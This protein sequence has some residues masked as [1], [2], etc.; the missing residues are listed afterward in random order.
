MD[1]S[2]A[3]RQ[4]K[5]ILNALK[6]FAREI[7][8]RSWR[9]M[10]FTL[11]PL[12]LFLTGAALAPW[13]PIRAVC[14]IGAGL[15]MIRGFI[16]Y[17]DF[18]HGAILRGSRT[19]GIFM[20]ALAVLML[21]PP[22]SWRET[23]NYHHAHVG[24]IGAEGD[25]SAEAI[26]TDI[27]SFPLLSTGMWSKLSRAQ[28]FRY[29]FIRHPLTIAFA[30]LTVFMMSI[31]LGSL[32]RNPRKHWPSALFFLGHLT[33]LAALGWA[34]G[35]PMVVFVGV[36]PMGIAAAL[37]AYLF[38]AQH[39]FPGVH[40]FTP[41][42]WNFVRASLETASYLKTGR[43]M[44]WITGCIGYHHV[45]HLN[46][47]IPF[48]RLPEAMAAVPELQYPTTTRLRP[49]DIAGCFRANLWDEHSHRMVSYRDA[50][51]MAASG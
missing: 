6:P 48:Y 26:A 3:D 1:S 5:E 15:M 41:A 14:S 33:Y 11:L 50:A 21:T 19:A 45:H 8:G 31:C 38:Y 35:W 49:R 43:I 25:K 23:H 16:L 42:E 24:R 30:Y 36:A 7:P 37:G 27:G 17:H 40:V 12:V 32:F 46:S 44:R 20:N 9:E 28:R 2:Q 4:N 22:R 18:M 47:N 10:V 29:R 13:W 51:F 39:S 34:G